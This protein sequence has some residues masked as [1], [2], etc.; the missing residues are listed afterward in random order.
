VTEIDK[1]ASKG[2]FRNNDKHVE[3]GEFALEVTR[4]VEIIWPLTFGRFVARVGEK[5]V[6]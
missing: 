4:K 1:V 6:I 3:K 5:P 2:S